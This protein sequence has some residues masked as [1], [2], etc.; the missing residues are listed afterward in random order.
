MV[1][2]SGSMQMLMQDTRKAA[3]KFLGRTLQEGDQAFLV[4]F[5]LQPRLLR[6]MTP[7]LRQLLLDLGRLNA[8]GRTAMYDAVVF[9]L[10]Q[11]EDLPGRRALVILT[12]GDDL[13]SRFG[14]SQSAEMAR[15]AG[16]LVYVI[17]L[18]A[19]DGM[20]RTFAKGDLR[21]VTEGTGGRLFLVDS[22]EQL[23]LAYEVINYELRSQYT[24]TLYTHGDLSD[25]QKK[26][27]KVE[28]KGR[29]DLQVRTVIG[30]GSPTST[31]P[32]TPPARGYES[33]PPPR[34]KPHAIFATIPA[35]CRPLTAPG[36]ASFARGSKMA[37]QAVLYDEQTILTLDPLAHIRLRSGMYIGR[38]GN[39][40]NQNDGIYVLLKEVVDNAIDE[41]IMGQ[42]KKIEINLKGNT[43]TVRD[44]GRG[45]PLGK[46]VDC[47]SK[48]HTGGKYNDDVFQFSV[49]LNGVGTKAV[50]ALAQDFE[51]CSLAREARCKRANFAQGRLL[52]E[53]DGDDPKGQTGTFV[54]FTPD[55]EIFGEYQWNEEFIYH[56]L[57]YYAYLNS[58]LSLVYNGQTFKS[59]GGLRDLLTA[60][61][62]E[63]E[64]LYEVMHFKQ[65][66][67]EIAFTHTHNYGETYFSLRQRPV[68]QRRRHPPRRLPRRPAQRH[69]RIRQEDLL[70]RRR[71][72]RHHRRG[73]RQ[74]AG[75]GFREPDQKQARLDRH[76]IL[77][78]A[79]RQGRGRTLAAPAQRRRRQA[80]HQDRKQRKA[81]QGA[82]RGQEAGAR[83][84]QKD[85]HPHPQADRLQDPPRRRQP[86]RRRNRASS[87]PK[88]TPP[89]APWCRPATSTPRRSFRSKASRSTSSASSATPSTPTKSSTTSCARWASRRPSKACAT[90]KS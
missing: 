22:F 35:L 75:P 24:L 18:G 53:E 66:K 65:D 36:R 56:R 25:E 67:L 82:R 64:P 42:G 50:N 72:R 80:D 39:G 73:R 40:S 10:L 7:D 60:E 9:A 28:V 63:E 61:L 30:R 77:G 83:T 37:K 58:G 85:R 45:I 21:K 23:D 33:P 5:D 55:P 48:M 59:Q 16:T 19:L 89:A 32:S 1:D 87:S 76:Q 71:A 90:T 43:V 17:G 70:R 44:H 49:G 74:A 14:P 11:Y 15:D 57:R 13:D 88:A 38:I 52:T 41:F 31:G 47:V 69:Q 27:I 26:S 78:G 6:P 12:D 8:D 2:S 86:A 54:S 3:A 79:R 62:G 46:V 29:K 84:R 4:D 20:P 81:A 51:V 68:H 34:Y